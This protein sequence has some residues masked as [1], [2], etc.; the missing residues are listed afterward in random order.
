MEFSVSSQRLNDELNKIEA[1]DFTLEEALGFMVN[2]ISDI[3]RE[4]ETAKINKT[5]QVLQVKDEGRFVTNFCS[6]AKIISATYDKNKDLFLDDLKPLQS[7]QLEKLKNVT[8]DIQELET[9]IQRLQKSGSELEEK[10]KDIESGCEKVKEYELQN[11]E[12]EETIRTYQNDINKVKQDY[13]TKQ[14]KLKTIQSDI[15][16]Y[17]N[18]LIPQAEREVKTWRDQFDNLSK[19][20]DSLKQECET[21]KEE[22]NKL[23]QQNLSLEKRRG[24]CSESLSKHRTDNAELVDKIKEMKDSIE[25]LDSNNKENE[26]S[27]QDLNHDILELRQKT[28]DLSSEKTRLEA[29]KSVADSEYKAVLNECK[30]LEDGIKDLTNEHQELV[31]R[32]EKY[33]DDI[34]SKKR[35]NNKLAKDLKDLAKKFDDV[36][37]E[38]NTTIK[39]IDGK[40]VDQSK[41]EIDLCIQ[42]THL[43]RVLKNESIQ[44]KEL[45]QKNEWINKQIE[46]LLDDRIINDDWMYLSKELQGELYNQR[47]E[48]EKR[49]NRKVL[50]LQEVLIELENNN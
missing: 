21:K 22:C 9:Q 45:N 48:F 43:K 15:S 19:Q 26:N 39:Q 24:E 40:K 2:Y 8:K 30:Q 50:L 46:K 13:K 12:L 41:L 17:E 44:M 49:L 47:D 28:T 16:R 34:V 7:K 32:K 14:N 1:K 10:L 20:R 42:L 35:E 5:F 31:K 37:T 4:M 3:N 36:N 18:I 27:I 33:Q 29:E 6:F 23:V 38:Y 25:E 11:N